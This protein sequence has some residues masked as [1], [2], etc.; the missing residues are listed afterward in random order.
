MKHS[1]PKIH[2]IYV[3]RI[4]VPGKMEISQFVELCC[5]MCLRLCSKEFNF[6]RFRIR[7]I[8]KVGF[9][10]T[11]NQQIRTSWNFFISPKITFLFMQRKTKNAVHFCINSWVK[12]FFTQS[13]FFILN[14]AILHLYVK[15]EH[16]TRL[17]ILLS[18]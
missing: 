2:T 11:C 18:P 14:R 4:I 3:Q 1:V 8:C 15:H 9:S 16:R 12:H 5:N 7:S 6:L 17:K 10:F 13:L